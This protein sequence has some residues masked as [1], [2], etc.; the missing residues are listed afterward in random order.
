MS[1]QGELG[2]LP[3]MTFSDVSGLLVGESITLTSV[4]ADLQFVDTSSLTISAA[5]LN[6]Y[7]GDL[8]TDVD[9]S[10]YGLETLEYT[11]V[12]NDLTSSATLVNNLC[13][14]AKNSAKATIAYAI[15]GHPRG[16]IGE[17]E[18]DTTFNTLVTED[19]IKNAM[20]AAINSGSAAV[21]SAAENILRDLGLSGVSGEDGGRDSSA[22]F[23]AGD[24]FEFNMLVTNGNIALVVDGAAALATTEGGATFF[25]GPTADG[26]FGVITPQFSSNDIINNGS[27]V[28][29]NSYVNG[30]RFSAKMYTNYTGTGA[31]NR[32]APVGTNTDS[33][34]IRLK[35]TLV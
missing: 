16:D 9:L 19:N 34:L 6:N 28:T 13:T 18:N 2:I 21:V 32:E 14:L 3:S 27:N 4:T 8:V 20:A 26:S 24:T 10:T 31:G 15:T 29:K 22:P 25:S 12:S 1:F 30:N 11:T 35:L 5:I 17:L 23:K 7:V 33:V